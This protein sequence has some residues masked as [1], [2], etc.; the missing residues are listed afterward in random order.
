MLGL[1]FL[2]NSCGELDFT[3]SSSGIYRVDALVNSTALSECSLITE[4]DEIY[5]YFAASVANDPDVTGLVVYLESPS[6]QVEGSRVQYILKSAEPLVS[7]T[8]DDGEAKP[9]TVITLNRLD[10]KL[11]RFNLPP[12]LAAGP[13]TMVFQVLG[14]T[15]ILHRGDQAVYYLG[16]GVFTLA[17]IQC[18]LPGVS[19]SGGETPGA[20][21][22]HLVPPGITVMLDVK[23]QSDPQFDP[24]VVWYNGKKRISEGK[25]SDGAGLILWKAPEQT[26][27]YTIRVE[28]FPAKPD[29]QTAGKFREIFLPVSSKVDS[30]GY[31]Y[32]YG[33]AISQWYK[34]WGNLGDSM[35]PTATEKSLIPRGTRPMRWSPSEG[36]YGLS[37]GPEDIYLLP[38]FT[39]DFS[40]E[41]K[42]GGFL[43]RFKSLSPG[44]VFQASFR[45]VNSSV[46]GLRMSLFSQEDSCSLVL[47]SGGRSVKLSA[48]GSAR[49]GEF[50]AAAVNFRIDDDL[51]TVVLDTGD[52]PESAEIPLSEGL[53]GGG[54][55]QFGAER[56]AVAGTA[57]PEDA[58]TA[59]DAGPV[60]PVEDDTG[61]ALTGAAASPVT[62]AIIDEFAIINSSGLLLSGDPVQENFTDGE[63]ARQKNPDNG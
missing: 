17:D 54:S 3:F 2:F 32:R 50:I 13:Y 59:P 22:S 24:Y 23:V 5:P 10:S 39:F 42:S 57:S 27:F 56:T 12:D 52:Q 25:Y 4:T 48:A 31:F 1:T 8:P 34:F 30:T 14:G 9:D 18:Y 7:D 15:E 41:E 49:S 6:G 28:V 11:P 60:G 45:N 26:G 20:R 47:E 37:I 33:E 46:E 19:G 55:L 44:L 40:G 38:E 43:F 53:G 63:T 16:T 58:E 61:T 51:F 29:R 35:A 21:S 62:T 36:L